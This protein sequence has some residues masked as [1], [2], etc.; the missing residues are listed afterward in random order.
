MAY[1]TLTVLAN[2]IDGDELLALMV[3]AD[4]QANDGFEFANDGRTILF[5]LDQLAAGAGDTLTFEANA[6]KY[7]NT[8]S[9][10]TRTITAKKAYMYGP[11]RP[12]EWNKTG[13]V[14]RCKF[15]TAAAT[16]D[17]IAVRVA[18]PK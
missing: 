10:L 3:G 8:P 6:D 18:N 7:G 2:D 15:T 1:T 13:G 14:V 17:L 5:V 12:E 4:T 16:T 11:F 9:P